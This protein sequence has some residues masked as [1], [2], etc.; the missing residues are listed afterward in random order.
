[1]E[2]WIERKTNTSY[3]FSSNFWCDPFLNSFFDSE[4]LEV[5]LG[6]FFRHCKKLLNIMSWNGLWS[7][8]QK[9]ETHTWEANKLG[10][11]IWKKL[12]FFS[13]KP[14][15]LSHHN[16]LHRVSKISITCGCNKIYISHN[17]E[18]KNSFIE[19]LQEKSLSTYYH[20]FVNKM[21]S[22]VLHCTNAKIVNKPYI[23]YYS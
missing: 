11:I 15:H 17:K 2:K 21:I 7:S 14:C 3:L 9:I 16:S 4:F 5:F 13:P 12:Q 10:Q 19:T 23:N 1:M 18:I 6:K 22:H 8:V 20:Q